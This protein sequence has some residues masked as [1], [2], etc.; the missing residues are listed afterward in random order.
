MIE[1]PRLSLARGCLQDDTEL[2]PAR[3]LRKP[4]TKCDEME[5]GAD[6]MHEKM[7]EMLWEARQNGTVV[8]DADAEHIT[9]I[10][11][12]YE[13]QRLQ[14]A[15]TGQEIVGWKLG[16]TAEASMNLLGL[17]EPFVGPIYASALQTNGATVAI[18]V[19]HKNF[20]ESEI[21]LVLNDGLTKREA[22]YSADE[23][24]SRVE[25][26]HAAIEVVG[27]RFAGSP[28]GKGATLIGDGAGNTACL[29]GS[30]IP[31]ELFDQPENCDVFAVINGEER[32]RG[33]A[34]AL[35][36]GHVTE[37]LQILSDRQ[38]SLPRE[39]QAGDVIMTG[40]LTGMLPVQVGDS[41]RAKFGAHAEV[42]VSFEAA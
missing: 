34:G 26:V 32:A 13:V 12:G 36:Y 21:A 14:A 35:I 20:F 38:H 31:L 8:Y 27:M 6:N 25:R 2:N 4:R 1:A 23:L 41:A 42:D 19:E 29:L 33:S 39:L 15:L 9:T 30:E 37:A 7:A 17:S 24:R 22:R 5:S 16:A 11:T 18:S 3:Q 40:T 28:E 10:E